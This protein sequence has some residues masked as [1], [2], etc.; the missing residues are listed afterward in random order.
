[1]LPLATLHCRL[2]EGHV[3]HL[4]LA[5]DVIYINMPVLPYNFSFPVS[6]YLAL[7]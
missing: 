4:F 5:N 3:L 7:L 6:A 1:M 2:Q